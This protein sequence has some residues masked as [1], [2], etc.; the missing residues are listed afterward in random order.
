[1]AYALRRENKGTPS[2]TGVYEGLMAPAV[3]PELSPRGRLR[4][5]PLSVKSRRSGREGGG[6]VRLVTSHSRLMSR[7][8]G[9][10]ANISRPRLVLRTGP[11][12][13]GTSC[14]FSETGRWLGSCRRWFRSG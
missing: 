11:I 4:F 1:M 8:A 5:G 10:P 13:T 2:F 6:I 12:S 3:R 9:S 7:T 14:P